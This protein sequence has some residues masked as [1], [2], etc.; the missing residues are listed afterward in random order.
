MGWEL[1]WDWAKILT[2]QRI[3][4]KL[5]DKCLDSYPSFDNFP[6]AILESLIK[7][8]KVLCKCTSHV[9]V[10]GKVPYPHSSQNDG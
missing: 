1:R 5:Q 6:I 4:Q 10:V 2:L 8:Y 3:K 7:S 9:S